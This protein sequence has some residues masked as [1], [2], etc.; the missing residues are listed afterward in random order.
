MPPR[1]YLDLAQ[2]ANLYWKVFLMLWFCY[3][4]IQPGIAAES[5][6]SPFG[7]AEAAVDRGRLVE[8]EKLYWQSKQFA[9]REGASKDART[10]IEC[11]LATCM[12][13]EDKLHEAE[14]LIANIKARLLVPDLVPRT[15]LN[16]LLV[17]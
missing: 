10:L 16:L 11:R 2:I 5:W 3:V 17:T 9:E 13:N 15:R 12:M 6:K 4:Q 7:Q 14:P 1:R 8:A